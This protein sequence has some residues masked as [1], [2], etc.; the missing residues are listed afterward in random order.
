MAKTNYITNWETWKELCQ[1]NDVDPYEY[2]N[3]GI[4]MGG[5]DSTDFEYI[6]DT[7]ERE[8]DEICAECGSFQGKAFN[9]AGLCLYKGIGK[10]LYI[11]NRNQKCKIGQFKK[12]IQ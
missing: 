2:V 1:E 12:R 5:G 6:G 4:D 7:P 8:G 9:E 10:G 11:K 3:F